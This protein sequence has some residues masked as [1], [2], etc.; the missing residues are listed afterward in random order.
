ML[1]NLNNLVRQEAADTI[2]NNPAIP[3]EK[4][5]AAIQ[6]ASGS[7]EEVLQEKA[8]RG[9]LSEISGLFKGGDMMNNP[10]VQQ[11]IQ[12]FAGKLGNLGIDPSAATGAA[13]GIIP[14]LL[15]KFIN[16]TNDPNDKGFDLQS[17]MTQF[18][19]PD[20][21]FQMSDVTNMFNTES[22]ERKGEGNGG[23]GD[24]VGG[25]FKK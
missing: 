6:A 13:S 9:N 4:N 15:E 17:M 7:V 23:L 1:E 2:V 3:S 11:I 20:G 12:V 25:F 14:G 10:I 21:K 19:G 24:A 16:R 5:E 18:L 8:S 22:G